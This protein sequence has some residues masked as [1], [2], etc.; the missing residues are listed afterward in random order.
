MSVFEVGQAVYRG[1]LSKSDRCPPPRQKLPGIG[2]ML[3]GVPR[4]G[5]LA[6][7]LAPPRKD[8]LVVQSVVGIHSADIA[9][10]PVW[11]RAARVP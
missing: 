4:F 6:D 8:S 5:R 3:P 10:K 11:H 2:M 7:V 1:D 9:I